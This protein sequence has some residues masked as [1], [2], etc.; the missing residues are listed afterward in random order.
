MKQ[1][2]PG[3]SG[4]TAEIKTINPAVAKAILATSRRNRHVTIS[5]V[6]KLSQAMELGEWIIAQP[7]MVNCD[8]TLLDGQHRLHAV[9][10]SGKSI[11][12]LVI[13]GF[14]SLDTF[15]R[16]DDVATRRLK[17]WLQIRGESLPDIL[18]AVVVMAAK[19]ERGM[20]PTT[21]GP[22]FQ[23][24]APEGIDYL[25]AHDEIRRSVMEAPATVTRYASRAMLCFCHYKFAQKDRAA[26]GS[27][28]IDLATGDKEG[29][30][31]PI[32]LLRERLKSNRRAKTKLPRTEMLALIY[33]SWNAVRAGQKLHNLRWRSTG[34]KAETFP[35]VV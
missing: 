26:A 29:E 17:D 23:M 34:P 12:F 20:I 25:E 2:I 27:F 13:S 24:T 16:I 35:E 4:L 5:R 9:I 1:T 30:R 32:Y 10:R 3:S 14:E 18:A 6:R 28:L 19:D 31:D 15:G 33:K 21:S 7:I 22:G 8:G 11:Q